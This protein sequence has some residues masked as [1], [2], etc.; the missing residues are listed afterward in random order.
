MHRF[1]IRHFANLPFS[2]MPGYTRMIEAYTDNGKKWAGSINELINSGKPEN[3]SQILVNAI[4]VD[5]DSAYLA[6]R[7][8]IE[9]QETGESLPDAKNPDESGPDAPT[10]RE[11]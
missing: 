1:L 10:K 6:C 3:E 4:W 7:R 11:G 5:A 2:D 8:Y 9:W